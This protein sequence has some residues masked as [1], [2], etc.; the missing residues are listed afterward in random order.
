M[1]KIEEEVHRLLQE[2][3]NNLSH[4]SDGRID[5]NDSKIAPVLTIFV[6]Y[7]NNLLL[8][9]RSR[10]VSTYKEKWNTVAGYL[11]NPNQSL[12]D[13]I[14]EELKEELNISKDQISSYFIGKKYQFTDE[15]NGRTWIVHPALV[16]L[17]EKPEIE[18]NWEHTTYTWITADQIK[19]YDVVPNLKKSMKR[20]L[21]HANIED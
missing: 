18:L 13:K 21:T 6:T 4:F 15:N 9:K 2:F 5:Y 16:T 20:T 3:S 17:N 11:D 19:E 8:L 7:H 12:F 14:L 1:K 10:D